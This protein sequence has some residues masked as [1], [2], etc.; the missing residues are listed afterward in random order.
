MLKCSSPLSDGPHR[1]RLVNGNGVSARACRGSSRSTWG[2][3]GRIGPNNTGR[4]ERTRQAGSFLPDRVGLRNQIASLAFKARLMGHQVMMK[5]RARDESPDYKRSSEQ[6]EAWKRVVQET[7]ITV[8]QAQDLVKAYG[9]DGQK[10]IQ[11]A[12][13]LAMPRPRSSRV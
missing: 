3:Y 11:A 10:L 1:N 9:N 4:L 7:G 2:P 5:N 13:L 6:L 8:E 12:R